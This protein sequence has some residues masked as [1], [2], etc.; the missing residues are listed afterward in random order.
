MFHDNPFK[1]DKIRDNVPNGSR[2]SIFVQ[3]SFKDFCIGPHVPSTGN[4]KNVMLLSL[5]STNY[6]GDEKGEKLVR[7]YGIFFPL[8]KELKRR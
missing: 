7:I 3:G 1:I 6:K 5:A 2:S 4:L 8:D